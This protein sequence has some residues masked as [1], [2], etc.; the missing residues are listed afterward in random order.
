MRVLGGEERREQVLV[1]VPVVQL[2]L[3]ADD[4]GTDVPERDD[5]LLELVRLGAVLG[6]EDHDELPAS[7]QEAVVACLRLCLGRRVGNDD[8]LERRAEGERLRRLPRLRIVGFEQ[9]LDVELRPRVVEIGDR[10]DQ[11]RQDLGLVVERYEDRVR[12]QRPVERRAGVALPDFLVHPR[13]RLVRDR[14]LGRTA[15]APVDQEQLVRG[16][17]DLERDREARERDERRDRV[18]HEPDDERE[19]QRRED[20]LLPAREYEVCGVVGLRAR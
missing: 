5:R 11:M 14:E 19:C 13:E 6:V 8:E 10:G 15:L 20:D 2:R 18:E 17:R 3:D 12:R 16:E 1:P 7:E 9:Q 4:V